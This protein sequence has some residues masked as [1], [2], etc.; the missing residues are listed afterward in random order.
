[1]VESHTLQVKSHPLSI[2][3]NSCTNLTTDNE[4][5]DNDNNVME[6]DGIIINGEKSFGNETFVVSGKQQSPLEEEVS[7]CMYV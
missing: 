4:M 7:M 3:H 2:V 5:Y 6:V 1:M